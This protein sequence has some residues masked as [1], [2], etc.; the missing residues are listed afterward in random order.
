MTDV[1][2]RQLFTASFVALVAT[3]FAFM[4]RV[5]LMDEW[6]AEFSM[7][8]TEK[9]QVFGAGFWPFGVSIVV[10]SLFIDRVGYRAAFLFAF[11]CHVGFAVMT[12]L[13]KD[14]QMLYWGSVIG[15]L[16]NGDGDECPGCHAHGHDRA[17]APPRSPGQNALMPVSS[18]PIV[19]W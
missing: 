2:R 17:P 11:V 9:G 3:A 15:A 5:L 18:R 6:A 8:E 14:Y 13:A 12:I 10:F 7:S 19:S 4:L 16:G 1:A